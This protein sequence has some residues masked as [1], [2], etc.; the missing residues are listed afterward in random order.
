MKGGGGAVADNSFAAVLIDERTLSDNVL[1]W[2]N[3]PSLGP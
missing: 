1:F 2:L 3:I